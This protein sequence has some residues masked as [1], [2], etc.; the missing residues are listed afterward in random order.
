MAYQIKGDINV[1]RNITA[2]EI[3]VS[4]DGNLKYI[5]PTSAGTSGK[6]IFSNGPGNKLTFQDTIKIINNSP[7]S[8]KILFNVAGNEYE[9]DYSVVVGK[10]IETT[11]ELSAAQEGTVS[12]EELFSKW[13]RFTHNSSGP[14]YPMTNDLNNLQGEQ[15]EWNYNSVSGLIENTTNSTT[16][17]G[18][19]SLEKTNKYII[20]AQLAS[21]STD[22]DYIGIVIAFVTEGIPG[23]AGYKEHTLTVWRTNNTGNAWRIDYNISGTT[24]YHNS[25]FNIAKPSTLANG[26][27]YTNPGLLGWQAAG[28]GCPIQVERDGDNIT[29]TTNDMGTTT[30]DSNAVYSFSLTDYPELEKFRGNSRYGF[31]SF[32]QPNSSWDASIISGTIYSLL[33]NTVYSYNGTTWVETS[34]SVEE[35]LGTGRILANPNT[36]KIFFIRGPNDYVSLT[37]ASIDNVVDTFSSQDI[38]GSKTFS[39]PININTSDNSGLYLKRTDVSSL[40]SVINITNAGRNLFIQQRNEDNSNPITIAT[41]VSAGNELPSSHTVVTREKGDARYAQLD[42]NNTLAGTLTVEGNTVVIKG[43]QPLLRLEETDSSITGSYYYITQSNNRTD[44]YFYNGTSVSLLKRTTM[45][46][47]GGLVHSFY[48]GNTILAAQI[49]AASDGLPNLASVI[50]R[51]KGDARYPQLAATNTFAATQNAT[52]WSAN[53]GGVGTPT[54]RFT[55]QIGTGFSRAAASNTI[56]VSLSS[57]AVARF[58]P[59]GVSTTDGITLITREKGDARYAQLGTFN[60]FTGSNLQEINFDMSNSSQNLVSFNILGNGNN[61]VF[62]FHRSTNSS[63]AS[64]IFYKGDG[65][66]TVEARIDGGDGT[67]STYPETVMTREK[68]DVRYAQLSA[69]NTFSVN[70]IIQNTA[71]YLFFNQT[72]EPAN[73]RLFQLGMG[74]QS[75]I[76]FA[77]N[78]NLSLRATMATIEPAGTSM[79]STTTVVTQ[80]KGDARYAQLNSNNT[81]LGQQ[82]I[83][84]TNPIFELWDADGGTN[85]KRWYF[86]LG[87]NVLTIN[88]KTD[89]GVYTEQPAR[90][91]PVGTTAPSVTTIITRQ[92]GDARYTQI[93]SDMALKENIQDAPEALPIIEQLRPV[94]FTWKDTEEND[95]LTHFGLIAQ[96]VQS[97][98]PSAVRDAGNGLGLEL[99][100]LMGLMIKS[101]KEMSEKIKHLE[102]IITNQS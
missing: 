27:L 70:P 39:R 22:D 52:I 62:R 74:G 99:K 25:G 19:V 5:L 95:S 3:T 9:P 57:V 21:T 34:A 49:D 96:E 48:T 36:N 8:G 61:N 14:V 55:N 78:D 60:T 51:E 35:E 2:K 77:L 10:F 72:D 29:I 92:K 86:S 102:S 18:L 58:E 28:V 31:C 94:Q 69:A 23:Q 84:S 32:S 80:E 83:Q 89:A 45:D 4:A 37:D 41:I 12:Q 30:L 87:N 17:I 44:H 88:R 82:I 90:I 64:V 1:G 16:I 97:V 15:T 75:M 42:T 46:A 79:N 50:T 26:T 13:Y 43:V 20:N 54:F 59:T 73:N 6:A 65:S 71:P 53:D 66:L 11:A 56:Q 91:D 33:D 100:D 47:N 40:G 7:E 85:E 63:S 81:L 98:L 68:G 76:L 101:M 38:G 67:T 93:S 24:T